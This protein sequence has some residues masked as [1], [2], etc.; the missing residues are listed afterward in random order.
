MPNSSDQGGSDEDARTARIVAETGE[1]IAR[2]DDVALPG[3][4][5]DAIEAGE[6]AVRVIRKHR[7]LTQAALAQAVGVSQG[8]VAEIEAGRK[9]GTPETLRACAKALGVPLDVLVE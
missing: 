6:N 4:V 9:T 7:G 2:G 1:A 8:Y 5:W 3:E